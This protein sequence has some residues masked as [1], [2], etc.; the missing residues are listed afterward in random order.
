MIALITEWQD[1]DGRIE[2]R[3]ADSPISAAPCAWAR[4]S[5][6]CKPGTLAAAIYGTEVN[7]RHRHR[8]EVNNL[9]VPQLEARATASRRARRAENLPR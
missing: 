1:R 4:R 2:R 8:Y 5:A 9:Y 6:R 7:E 3:D